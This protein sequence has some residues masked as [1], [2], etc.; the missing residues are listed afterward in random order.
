[1]L[2]KLSDDR[3][4]LERILVQTLS[5]GPSLDKVLNLRNVREVY[6]RVGRPPGALKFSVPD[7]IGTHGQIRVWD[8]NFL[9]TTHLTESAERFR[10]VRVLRLADWDLEHD[11]TPQ[12]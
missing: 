3:R 11:R 6:W 9:G 4:A 1:M 10:G 5:W 7:R 2:V 8:C 12:L